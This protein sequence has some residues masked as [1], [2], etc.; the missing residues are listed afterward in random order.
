MIKFKVIFIVTLYALPSQK[1]YRLKSSSMITSQFRY[2][3]LFMCL[4][5]F[6]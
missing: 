4:H 2:S 1:F 6:K 5:I 3:M